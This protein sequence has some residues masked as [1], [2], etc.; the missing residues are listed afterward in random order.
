M[1]IRKLQEI[2]AQE[3]DDG[4]RVMTVGYYRLPNWV[5]GLEHQNTAAS[6][7]APPFDERSTS[8]LAWLPLNG[9]GY[10]QGLIW[11]PWRII[12]VS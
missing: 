10:T 5:Y 9:C 11:L 8:N 1:H 2:V 7:S 3:W 4:D 12:L 6:A